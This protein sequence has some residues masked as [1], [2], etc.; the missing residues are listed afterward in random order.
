[1]SVSLPLNAATFAYL[2]VGTLAGL[3]VGLLVRLAGKSA[4]VALGK[5]ALGGGI[6]GLFVPSLLGFARYIH[7]LVG[8]GMDPE[9]A[10]FV[11]WPIVLLLLGL[12]LGAASGLLAAVCGGPPGEGESRGDGI[13]RSVATGAKMGARLGFIAGFLLTIGLFIFTFARSW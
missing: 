9:D 7:S 3:L 2:A 8:S 10:V 6:C 11:P 13:K 4:K 5:W 12:A 1:V